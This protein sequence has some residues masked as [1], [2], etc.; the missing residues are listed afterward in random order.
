LL[1]VPIWLHNW[2]LL[3]IVAF[4]PT[5]IKERYENGGLERELV[6]QV[7]VQ[8]VL[9]TTIGLA[10]QNAMRI[11]EKVWIFCVPE[12]GMSFVTSDNPVC[13][14]LPLRYQASTNFLVALY[15]P[16][17][18]I[19]VALRK[20]FAVRCVPAHFYSNTQ[21]PFVEGKIC[22]FGTRGTKKAN[23]LIAHAARRYVYSSEKS[24]AFAR[25][26]GRLKGTEQRYR[27]E[28][29]VPEIPIEISSD[30]RNTEASG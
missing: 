17:S 7:D 2:Y 13:F 1:Y 5:L 9:Q 3:G 19:F 11:F 26:V 15:H 22:R 16:M 6:L 28:S 23:K 20:D 24:E 8:H 29:G 18:A 27:P 4:M 10:C 12:R 21:R 14:S 30:F 25:M